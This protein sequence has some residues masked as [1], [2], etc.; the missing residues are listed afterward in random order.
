MGEGWLNGG[1]ALVRQCFQPHPEKPGRLVN[2]RLLKERKK[3]EEWREKS[4]AGGI[5]S[6]QMRQAKALAKANRRAKGGSRVVE[7]WSNQTPTLQSSSSS[8]KEDMFAVIFNHWKT[9]HAHPKAIL[10]AKRRRLISDRLEEGF[11]VDDLNLAIDGCKAS[12]W[13]M[14]EN[15]RRKVFDS[16]D[17]I[18]R[19]ASHVEKF[20]AEV[21]SRNGHGPVEPSRPPVVTAPPDYKQS[22]QRG[23]QC[24]T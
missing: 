6:G 15:D 11:S 13:H 3:Q 1:S 7:G 17:L 9:V 18:F 12:A 20:I 24:E 14:G 8:S 19:D 16:L 5:K 10:D 21:E 2:L 22:R 4:Q 23:D